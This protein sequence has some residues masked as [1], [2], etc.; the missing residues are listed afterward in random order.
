MIYRDGHW[1]FNHTPVNA[2]AIQIG[3]GVVFSFFEGDTRIEVW[4]WEEW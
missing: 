3:L 2:W 4:A 1:E